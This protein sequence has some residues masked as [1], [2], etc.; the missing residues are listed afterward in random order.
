MELIL[1]VAPGYAFVRLTSSSCSAIS[2][3]RADAD[4]SIAVEWA[5]GTT[6]SSSRSDVGG[7]ICG[8]LGVEV[9]FR[10]RFRDG[11]AGWEWR[12]SEVRRR[13]ERV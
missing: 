3:S 2:F 1:F 8:A 6:S 11:L 9:A 4:A 5:S 7:V 13:M 10:R 12:F